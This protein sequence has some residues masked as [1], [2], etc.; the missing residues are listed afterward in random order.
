MATIT[1][2]PQ[3]NGKYS[4]LVSVSLGRDSQGKKI[5]QTTTFTADSK[6]PTKARKEAEAFAVEYE[7]RVLS[8]DVLTAEKITFSEFAEIWKKNWLPA[9]TPVVRQNYWDVLKNRV[10]PYIGSLKISSIRATHIDKL[11]KDEATNGN[12]PNTI[13]MTFAVI[14]SV[15]K[16]AMKKQYIR[17]NPCIR[18]DDLPAVQMRTGN[19]LS[20][21]NEDQTRRFLRD[22]LTMD[23][24]ISYGQ[25]TRKTRSGRVYKVKAYTGHHSVS[26][27]WRIYFTMAIYGGFRRGE[28]CA[29]TWEDVDLDAHTVSINKAIGCTREDGQFVKSPKTKAGERCIVLPAEVFD[30]L[31]VWKR[32]QMTLCIKMGTAWK[33]HRN[34]IMEDGITKD[35]FDMNTIFIQPDNGL[36]ISISTPGHKFAEIIS[37]Y[38]STCA[39]EE[40][41][42]PKIRL[43]DL[44]HTSATLLLSKNTDIETIARRLGHSKPSVTLDIYGH[45]LPENDK[46][47]SA[48]LEAM[49]G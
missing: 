15:L 14:N 38:N 1:S 25:R 30:L 43:H 4:Y 22:A 19:D 17:E 45:A 20:F 29:L 24:D 42:L 40:D 9:K 7:K 6:A 3:K 5:R 33:G 23:Y 31:K 47:A 10:F 41:K 28:M 8:G 11:L 18:C 13:R 37:M 46:Q 48:A 35:R 27:Q 34:G 49:F 44:R 2:R 16:Y 21:F 26:L 32:E 12:A 36:P 39:R